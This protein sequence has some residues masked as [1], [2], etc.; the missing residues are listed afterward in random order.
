MTIEFEIPFN[1]EFLY[2]DFE[3][4]PKMEDDGIGSYEFWGAKGHD[5]R[6]Y[7]SCERHGIWWN[8]SLFDEEQNRVVGDYLDY[9]YEKIEEKF[10]NKFKGKYEL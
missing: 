2:V 9:N 8:R 7:L 4:D 6:P 5:S 10:C 1:E 3:A